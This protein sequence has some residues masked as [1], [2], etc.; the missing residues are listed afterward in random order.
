MRDRLSNSQPHWGHPIH[1]VQTISF[2]RV[3]PGIARKR[4]NVADCGLDRTK[5]IRRQTGG[6]SHGG[7]G[8]GLGRS[9]TSRCRMQDIPWD[10]VGVNIQKWEMPQLQPGCEHGRQTLAPRAMHVH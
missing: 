5:R 1:V 3:F 7:G 6:R 4:S 9:C 2:S 10:F 8:I